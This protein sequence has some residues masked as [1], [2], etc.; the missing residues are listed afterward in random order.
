M[1]MVKREEEEGGYESSVT[2]HRY[3][4]RESIFY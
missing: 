4:E 2:R 1:G 3:A